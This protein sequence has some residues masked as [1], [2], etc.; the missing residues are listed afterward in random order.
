MSFSSTKKNWEGL[1][2]KDPLW[3]ICTHPGKKGEKWDEKEFFL[4][5]QKEIDLLFEFLESRNINLPDN[6]L[7]VEFGCGVGRLLRALYPRFESLCGLD[8]SPT[9]IE[10]AELLNQEYLDKI[11][12]QTIQEPMLDIFD[13]GSVSLVISLIVFQH[14][15]PSYYSQYIEDLMRLVKPGGLFILQLITKDKRSLRWIKNIRSFIRI[16]ERLA[17]IGIGNHFQ[18]EMNVMNR[19]EIVGIIKK[20][21]GEIL[22]ILITN[23]TN[24][25]YE[26]SL[27]FVD[28]RDCIDYV[29]TLII[30]RKLEELNPNN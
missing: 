30:V 16:R 26:G 1:A 21:K 24:P 8:I 5:G 22:D 3:A 12:F 20:N 6:E 29:S 27:K 2:K 25:A 11:T 23:H 28:E 13:T 4:S 17:M 15:H 14:I 19:Q 18:M 9:M 7:V 10:K